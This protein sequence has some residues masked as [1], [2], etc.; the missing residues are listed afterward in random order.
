MIEENLHKKS[1]FQ[2]YFKINYD[3][4]KKKLVD[5]NWEN[6]YKITDV[7]EIFEY[8]TKTIL[9]L[10]RN[11]NDESRQK[12]INRAVFQKPWMTHKLLKLI[13]KRSKLHKQF[14]RE[15]FN[16]IIAKK[17]RELRNY[18]TNQIK[19]AKSHFYK[20]EYEKCNSNI[21]EKWKFI[22]KILKKDFSNS[23]GPTKLQIGDNLVIDPIEISEAM[24]GHFVNI[25]KNLA[26]G[27]P[28]SNSDFSS[29][30]TLKPVLPIEFNFDKVLE[31]KIMNVI[32]SLQLKK[33]TGIDNISVR[34]LQE[35][36]LTLIPIVTHLFNSVISSSTFP[37]CQKI[38]RIT[39]LFKKGS[40]SDPNNYRPIS[41]LPIL[42]KVIEKILTQQIRA[43]MEDFNL[44]I[45]NQYGFREKRNTTG[46]LNKLLEKL[47]VNFDSGLV[48]Y[49][50]F[51]DFSKAFDTVDHDI[52]L[53][54]LEFYNFSVESRN[55]LK[56]YLSNRLQYV[57]ISKAKSSMETVKIGVPQGSILGPLLF[58]IFINDLKNCAPNLDCIIF[59]DDTSIFSTDYFKLKTEL[60]EIEKW[61]ISNKLILN[62]LK[63]LLVPF[64]NSAKISNL[65]P[66]FFYINKTGVSLQEKT[67]F[68]GIT[69]D[70]NISFNYHI[71]ELCRKLNAINLMMRH[72]RKYVDKKTIIDIYYSFFYPHLIYGLEFW[73][74]AG[75]SDLNKIFLLQK[76]VLRIILCMKRN[77]SVS[78]NFKILRIMPIQMLFEYRLVLH[79]IKAYNKDEIKSML[80][81]HDHNTRLKSSNALQSSSF[82]T[83]KGQRSML[84]SA[85]NIYN[86]FLKDLID[87]A[88]RVV[89]VRLAERLW[90]SGYS[91]ECGP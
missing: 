91:R 60:T 1:H 21:N 2:N 64:K 70:Q 39:P 18:V 79:F 83:N 25:G 81:E 74:H 59:A 51:L 65:P 17:Y 85:V 49:G 63:T 84:F 35:N 12:N 29:Y 56:S 11:S 50:L 10:S 53:K 22:N 8:F 16:A 75:K 37:D 43:F 72:L 57:E 55:L 89:K 3:Q 78:K 73:G 76:Q 47:Y 58:I 36:K 33:A 61:C 13:N 30:L 69:L 71:K 66:D 46:A 9:E 5:Y 80:I 28:K 67:K 77:D 27:L 26:T 45:D 54:K 24:N 48:T 32:E 40:K 15:P 68:V 14:K 52:L 88:P 42:S 31:D 7:N 90:E 82:K 38:A 20:S 23:A 34:I 6:F 86:Q 62:G 4:L 87:L 44:F 19:D 41:I